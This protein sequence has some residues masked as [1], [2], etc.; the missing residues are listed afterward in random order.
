MDKD[1]T[2]FSTSEFSALVRKSIKQEKLHRPKESC[3]E[4]LKNFAR[5]YRA[6]MNMPDGL[7]GYML[8]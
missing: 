7:Q 6:N 3:I 5:N 2:H 1:Y 8:S 4:L